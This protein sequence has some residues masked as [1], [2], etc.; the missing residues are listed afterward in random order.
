MRPSPMHYFPLTTPFLILLGVILVIL[1]ALIELRALRY[2]YEKIG[3]SRQAGYAVLILTFVGSYINIPV[4]RLPPERMVK[5]EVVDYLGM[6]YVVPT[7]EESPGTIIAV[8]LGGA[9]IPT[10]VS[11]Y[12]LIRNR[13]YVRGIIAVGVVTIVVHLLAKPIRGVGIGVPIF[14]PPLVSAAVALILSRQQAPALAYIAG[15]LG[16]L[17]GADILNLHRIQGLGAPIASIGGAGTF[18]GVFLTGIL[19]VLITPFSGRARTEA[20]T[21]RGPHWAVGS[22]EQAWQPRG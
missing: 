4:A 12:L 1:V 17:L 10:L 22:P 11:L 7:V 18:D 6:K 8:N 13:L 19:A 21:G 2:A 20:E 9:L 14:V 5:E 3:L 16:A 15:C